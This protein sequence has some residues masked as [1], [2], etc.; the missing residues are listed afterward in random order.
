MIENKRFIQVWLDLENNNGC[1][2]CKHNLIN[3]C[4]I[5]NRGSVGNVK[6]ISH[7]ALR[8]WEYD[9]NKSK[10][11]ELKE[12]NEQLKQRIKELEEKNIDGE[13]LYL[14]SEVDKNNE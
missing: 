12:E 10:I 13:L 6:G 1:W 14:I 5:N 3:Y 11:F 9:R 2:D 8:N 4:E 7:C